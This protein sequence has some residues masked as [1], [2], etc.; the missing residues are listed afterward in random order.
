MSARSPM[1]EVLAET[2]AYFR[3][4]RRIKPL[5]QGVKTAADELDRF[6]V[7][8]YSDRVGTGIPKLDRRL[9]GGM[10]GGEM[11]LLGAPTG[12]GKTSLVSQ[13]AMTVASKGPVILVSPEMSIESLAEREIIRRS[14]RRLWDRNPWTAR[15]PWR[16]S[17]EAAHVAAA[18]ELI[19]EK[20]PVMVLDQGDVTMLE[21]EETA[22]E[23]PGLALVI[24]DYAQQVAGG[25]NDATPRY[26]Q[27][28]DVGTRSVA[29]AKELN[30]PVMVASQVNVATDR[31]KRSYAFRETAILEHKAHAVLIFDVEWNDDGEERTVSKASIICTKHRS[32]S[33]FRLPVHY[34]PALYQISDLVTERPGNYPLLPP[35]MP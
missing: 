29:L 8:D 6:S 33:A 16:E 25:A 12:G 4:V 26:L 31:G 5:W 27:V 11:Y 24:V 30:I 19:D 15:G 14:G 2:A 32:A 35:A 18:S 23:I 20:L 21:I 34:D 7:G 17:C 28:G 13:V 3:A 22:R 9:R 10:R 1:A